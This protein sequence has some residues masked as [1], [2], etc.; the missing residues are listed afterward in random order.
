MSGGAKARLYPGAIA[1]RRWLTVGCLAVTLGMP[2]VGYAPSRPADGGGCATR[3]DYVVLA[4]LADSRNSVGLS[5]Y[6]WEQP[7]DWH[8]SPS[9]GVQH[10]AYSPA[11]TAADCGIRREQTRQQ[12]G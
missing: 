8:F 9:L 6:R 10:V 3:F 7:V 4:S 11:S 2:A 5:T 1:V 12:T